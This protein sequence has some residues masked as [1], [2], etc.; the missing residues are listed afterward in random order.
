V[1]YF[2]PRI[3]LEKKKALY[4]LAVAVC[5]GLVLLPAYHPLTLLELKTYDYRVI[6]HDHGDTSLQS[7]IPERLARPKIVLV[8]I[9]DQSLNNV[10]Y[11]WPFERKLYGEVIRTINKGGAALIGVDVYFTNPSKQGVDDDYALVED[12]R[13]AGNVVLASYIS[14]LDK[15]R[16]VATIM[17]PIKIYID[18]A[19]GTGF[20]FGRMEI[21]NYIRRV[22]LF[23]FNEPDFY[24]SFPL[25]MVAK[26]LPEAEIDYS[27]TNRT[28]TI[29]YMTKSSGT[30]APPAINVPLSTG[31]SLRVH[32]F[33]EPFTRTI[34][35]HDVLRGAVPKNCFKDAIV[36][37]GPTAPVL[38]DVYPAPP[39][40]MSGV[41]IQG[42][43]MLTMLYQAFIYNVP[44]QV[45]RLSTLLY[46]VITALIVMGASPLA[47]ALFSLVL[48]VFHGFL[49]FFLL[50]KTSLWISMV[51]PV[52]AIALA[53][54]VITFMKLFWSTLENLRL[55]RLAITDGLTELYVHKYF[56]LKLQEESGRAQRHQLPLSLMITD[57]D[58]FKSFNDTYGHQIGDQVLKIV[59]Q[60]L[61]QSCRSTDTVARYGGE[62]FAV[63][64]PHSDQVGAL[65]MAERIRQNIE[66]TEIPHKDS[67][68]KV[69]TSIGVTT[70]Y[71]DD[72]VE[73]AILI[74]QAD[75]SLYHA[76]ETGRNRVVS[77]D[78]I[79]GGETNSDE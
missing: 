43:A 72:I 71:P 35:F 28:L 54:I 67:V 20:S 12:L 36:L 34:S 64:L 41:M 68:L 7:P 30:A 77:W 29:R 5:I 31:D 2:L 74:K 47:G 24:P 9:D 55:Y 14:I 59:A 65:N 70:L 17:D 78:T 48:V 13:E 49:S 11:G 61:K 33:P 73:P 44:W 4:A 23:H 37:I 8:S 1:K 15:E 60:T 22:K 3:I 38:H 42:N 56:Q 53:Y 32:F 52:L 63:I 10:G 19:S 45:D 62:E 39:G 40:N 50:V 6:R 79:K 57:I 16:E 25:T 51:K 66:N 46:A 69:T 21:D 75:Q 58:H 26:Y 27:S 76:K 18:A